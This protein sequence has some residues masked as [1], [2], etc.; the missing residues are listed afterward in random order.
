MFREPEDVLEQFGWPWHGQIINEVLTLP[1]GREIACEFGGWD[2]QLWEIGMP[3]PGIVA[4]DPDEQWWPRAIL[5]GDLTFNAWVFYS[6]VTERPGSGSYT[7]RAP[8]RAGGVLYRNYSAR[9]GLDGV[10]GG[11]Q[12][13]VEI[14]IQFFFR[15][16]VSRADMGVPGSS[17]GWSASIIDADLS[18]GR[19]I[20]RYEG[21]DSTAWAIVL[22][23]L[24]GSG[25]DLSL[26]T[27]VLATY[28]DCAQWTAS[29]DV[30]FNVPT[31]QRV[32]WL[33][34]V[35][36]SEADWPA[37]R[38]KPLGFYCIGE[39]TATARGTAVC[40]AWFDN[41]GAVQLVKL[42]AQ[43]ELAYSGE[44]P[45]L[46]LRRYTLREKTSIWIEVG[47]TVGGGIEHEHTVTAED[48]TTPSNGT[49][50]RSV[51]TVSGATVRDETLFFAGVRPSV[52]IGYRDYHTQVGADGYPVHSQN[53]AELF[54]FGGVPPVSLGPSRMSN[55][56]WQPSVNVTVTD[57]NALWLGDVLSPSGITP[58][59]VSRMPFAGPVPANFSRGT[60]NPIT[61]AVVRNPTDGRRY[62]W[63]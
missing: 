62:S 34:G 59:V 41:A 28:A 57:G 35:L 25:P 30:P 10:T 26:H 53:W 47:G 23:E 55:K 45:S 18:R 9:A 22:M 31:S 20:A 13:V 52:P 33:D 2:T 27:E 50:Q 24:R 6:G 40:G 7:Y 1:S 48:T 51:T 63:V 14:G 49:S 58:G 43:S 54:P 36:T 15:V 16:V 17:V 5:R 37:G 60:Y 11:L 32:E 3:D 42:G 21:P 19:W 44:W 39:H 12:L 38:P 8:L 61:G 29:E 4:D 56:L 46:A